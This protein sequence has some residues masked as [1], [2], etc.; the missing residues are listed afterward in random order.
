MS[1]QNALF[2]VSRVPSAAMTAMADEEDSMMFSLYSLS[3]RISSSCRR[4]RV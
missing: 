3:E 4:S 2:D 1:S